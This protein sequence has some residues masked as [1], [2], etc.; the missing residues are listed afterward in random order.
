MRHLLLS[1]ALLSSPALAEPTTAPKADAPAAA[2]L[3]VGGDLPK[4]GALTVAELKQL[5]EVQATWQGKA[6]TG[7]PVEAV[8]ARFGF[9]PGVMGHDV[10]KAE[11]RS[12]WKMAVV[13]TAADGFQ[14]AFSA[15]ELHALIGPSQVLIVTS[16]EGKPLPDSEGPLRLAVLTDKEPSRSIYQLTR[17]DVVDLRKLVKP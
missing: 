13:A 2:G 4:T 8:L 5:G 7:V 15:A 6:I 11:K 9:T 3:R 14:A 17:L 10:P 16:R 12:G 1:L